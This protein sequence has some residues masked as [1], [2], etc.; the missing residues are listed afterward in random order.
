MCI[1]LVDSLRHCQVAEGLLL[2]EQPC[3]WAGKPAGK[4]V[5]QIVKIPLAQHQVAE[6]LLLI[7]N[8]LAAFLAVLARNQPAAKLGD[9]R[10][11]SMPLRFPLLC[12]RHT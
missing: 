7:E 4:C 1:T 5:R 12:H 11:R 2:S 9:E 10:V 3:C 6:G 8:L